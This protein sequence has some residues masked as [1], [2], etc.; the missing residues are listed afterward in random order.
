MFRRIHDCAEMVRRLTGAGIIP[1]GTFIQYLREHTAEFNYR[2]GGISLCRD[3]F[4]LSET[5]GR[6]A[7]A[8]VWYKTFTGKCADA[9]KFAVQHPEFD[10]ALLTVIIENLKKM[11]FFKKNPDN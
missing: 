8:A 5:Y 11:Q 10:L 7:A 2:E 3:G 1:V 6:F 9:A 4:H